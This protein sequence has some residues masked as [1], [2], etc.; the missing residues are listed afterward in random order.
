MPTVGGD[1]E[2]Q[3]HMHKNAVL[4]VDLYIGTATNRT[5]MESTVLIKLHLP[6]LHSGR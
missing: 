3:A 4:V 5:H 6:W 1:K 2:S